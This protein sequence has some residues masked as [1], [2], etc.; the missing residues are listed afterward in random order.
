MHFT[1]STTCRR[2][3]LVAVLSSEASLYRRHLLSTA[4]ATDAACCLNVAIT[5]LPIEPPLFRNDLSRETSPSLRLSLGTTASER[6]QA[7]RETSFDESVYRAPFATTRRLLLLISS[8]YYKEVLG[9]SLSQ[10]SLPTTLST[11]K[12]R[13]PFRR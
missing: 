2:E 1:V 11:S 3:T 9:L 5:T 8:T 13:Y 4:L 12:Q 7:F 6:V 10:N